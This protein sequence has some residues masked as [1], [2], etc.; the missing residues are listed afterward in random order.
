MRLS[1]YSLP[2]LT[3][4][5]EV[6]NE[7]NTHSNYDGQIIENFEASPLPKMVVYGLVHVFE[8]AEV[9]NYE[10]TRKEREEAWDNNEGSD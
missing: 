10:Q 4:E 9:S 1:C 7:Q 3:D 6:Q 2:L 8:T 5:S